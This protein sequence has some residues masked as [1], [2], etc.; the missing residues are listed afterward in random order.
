M[1][2]TSDISALIGLQLKRKML[3]INNSKLQ[4]H[5]IKTLEEDKRNKRRRRRNRA[6]LQKNNLGRLAK[7]S[8]RSQ[9][10]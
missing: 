9:V 6:P 7:S 5:N 10:V 1:F 4:K 3:P 8:K 2:K